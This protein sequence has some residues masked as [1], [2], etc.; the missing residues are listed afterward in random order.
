L[1]AS[2]SNPAF[3]KR[4]RKDGLL[5]C[6]R[7]DADRSKPGSLPRFSLSCSSRSAMEFRFF[8]KKRSPYF[9]FSLSENF[10]K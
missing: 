2:R 9:P 4:H 10:K 3:L 7:N 8:C 6:A 5:R 1:P